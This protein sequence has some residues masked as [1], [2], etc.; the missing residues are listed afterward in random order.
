[1]P[2]NITKFILCLLLVCVPM[3]W[4]QTTGGTLSGKITS[5]SGAGVANAAVTIT[6]VSTNVSQRLLTGPDGTFTIAGL[7]PGTYKV[8]IESAGFKRT[9][10]QNIELQATGPSTINITLEPGSSAETV[11]VKGRAPVV[12]SENGEVST[13]VYTRMVGE[14]PVV[15]RNH[16]QLMQLQTGVTPPVV[17]YPKSV[18]T[19]RQ[20]EWATN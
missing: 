11:E 7:A 5:P 1:M 20:R 18:D 9:A 8:E 16:Q 13:G 4:A 14:L 15:D 6:N 12:Q 17:N 2:N 19:E 10:Q 3:V